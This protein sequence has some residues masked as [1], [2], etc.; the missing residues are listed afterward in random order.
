MRS[1]IAAI[2][3]SETTDLVVAEAAKLAKALDHSLHLIHVVKE[4]PPLAAYGFTPNAYPEA[5]RLLREA[6]IRSNELIKEIASSIDIDTVE[7][8]VIKGS[9]VNSIIAYAKE[10]DAAYIVLGSHGHNFIKSM[11]LGDL[12]KKVVNQSRIPMV[13]IPSPPQ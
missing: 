4:E 10:T 1:I 8:R 6:H 2:D 9:R 13:I 12:A 7:T 11:L 5:A 3:F